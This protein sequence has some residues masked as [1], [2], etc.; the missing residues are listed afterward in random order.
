MGARN[1]GVW[2]GVGVWGCRL[3][4]ER[5]ARG[6]FNFGACFTRVHLWLDPRRVMLADMSAMRLADDAHTL[7]FHCRRRSRNRA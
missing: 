3:C 2:E 5:S 4:V 1:G 6:R 7:P